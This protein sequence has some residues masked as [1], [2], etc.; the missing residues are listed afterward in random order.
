[1]AGKGLFAVGDT[2]DMVAYSRVSAD[3]G[4]VV[5]GEVEKVLVRQGFLPHAVCKQVE[6]FGLRNFAV[7]VCIEGPE[8]RISLFNLFLRGC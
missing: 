2:W 6:P 1:M 8:K 4:G 7:P 3:F 5:L